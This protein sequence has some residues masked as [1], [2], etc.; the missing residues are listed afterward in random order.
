[1]IYPHTKLPK[2]GTTIFSVV[3]E[4]LTKKNAIN[5]SQGFPDFDGPSALLEAVGR[6]IAQ[7]ANQ[8]APMTGVPALREQIAQKVA[9]LYGREVSVDHEITV[10]S[11]ATEAL[12]A[13]I[14]AVVRADDEVIIFDPAYDSYEPAI[15]L[16]GAKAVRLQLQAPDFRVNWDE[17]SAH[18]TDKTRLIIL[19][20]PHN[21]TGTTLDAD[22]LERLAELVEGTDIL[23]LGDEVYEHIVFDNA[24]HHSLLTHAQLYE[25]SFVVSSFGKTY[26]TTGWKVGYCVA[27]PALSVE[28]RKVHQYLTFSTS[29]PMQLALADIMRDEPQHVSELPAFYQHKRD[30]FCDLIQPSRFKFTPTSGTYFQCVDY[31]AISDLPDV[32]FCKWLIEKA[33]VAAIPVSVF[34]KAPP[35]IRLVR[36]CFAKSDETLRAAAERICAI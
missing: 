3:S 15:E 14:A 20:S 33:G 30:L 35:D 4:S 17:V 5:L 27:P 24:P 9:L 29:T 25:R 8:Y 7:G 2:V 26:H 10:T 28:L 12:F 6:Y 11:G 21:P 32:E 1:M 19:N 23:L 22:D 16:N 18:I 31:S 13:A 34:C 36:F